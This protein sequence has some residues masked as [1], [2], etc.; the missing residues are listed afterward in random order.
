[1]ASYDEFGVMTAVSVIPQLGSI[2]GMASAH[3]TFPRKQISL[4][5]NYVGKMNH[6]NS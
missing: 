2:R 3:I 1:M 6:E 4:C 5:S